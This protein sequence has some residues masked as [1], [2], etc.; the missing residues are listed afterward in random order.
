MITNQ[1]MGINDNDRKKINEI[2]V[3]IKGS[4]WKDRVKGFSEYITE[5][6]RSIKPGT[7]KDDFREIISKLIFMTLLRKISLMT[8]SPGKLFEYIFAPLIGSTA[9][10]VGTSDQEIVD[11]I[12][13]K[14]YAYQL[15]LFTGEKTDKTLIG[16]RNKF[17]NYVSGDVET[18]KK[19]NI[20]QQLWQSGMAASGGALTYIMSSADQSTNI[21]DFVEINVYID[22]MNLTKTQS[23]ISQGYTQIN[24]PTI[25]SHGAV[26]R[27][28]SGKN[29][30]TVFMFEHPQQQLDLIFG[31]KPQTSQVL[32]T[33]PSP[34]DEIGLY[35]K[36]YKRKDL[37]EKK[38]DIDANLKQYKSENNK[39]NN[40]QDK[41]K[42]IKKL[43]ELGIDTDQN[44]KSKSDPDL[45]K[46]AA[47]TSMDIQNAL[48]P[49]TAQA[50]VQPQ[51][52]NITQFS[53]LKPR[54]DEFNISLV[55]Q[56]EQLNPIK[57]DLGNY[58]QV[59]EWQVETANIV[60]KT[61]VD[62][63]NSFDSL[64]KNMTNYFGT[65]T[66]PNTAAYGQECVNDA[67]KITNGIIS[68]GASEGASIKE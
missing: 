58:K 8:S 65:A 55:S 29:F 1:N 57:M 66:S 54:T 6:N 9:R 40:A 47:S 41:N 23:F 30:A 43:V 32:K 21:V 51:P 35:N 46:I 20:S 34:D 15:K 12:N 48:V 42:I 3:G 5:V 52:Q 4:N 2:V 26:F 11:V 67:R 18:L 60:Q 63:L 13:D 45:A 68:I 10:V 7:G 25:R 16:S 61:M 53:G 36:T 37:I 31:A 56:W 17:R 22:D 19:L 24:D 14:G 49:P 39:F 44:L 28:D 59:N 38:R 50:T 33:K 64:G 27:D 62:V